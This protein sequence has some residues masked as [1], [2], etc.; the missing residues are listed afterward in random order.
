MNKH[1]RPGLETPLAQPLAGSLPRALRTALRRRH[2]LLEVLPGESLETGAERIDTAVMALFRD[3]RDSLAFECLYR[4]TSAAVLEWLRRL[5]GRDSRSLDPL[6]ALQDTFINV[7]QYSARFRDERSDSFRVW[8]RTIAANALRR[9]CGRVPR[10]FES[11]E[12]ANRPEPVAPGAEPEARLCGLEDQRR[13]ALSWMLFLD[14]YG[15]AFALLSDRDQAALTLVE[16]E[17]LSYAEAA[18]RLAVGSSNMKMIM[19]RARQRL[20]AHMDRSMGGGC[21]PELRAV[22]RPE[23][24]REAPAGKCPAGG[25]RLRAVG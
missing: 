13:L 10:Q 3:T 21:P 18:A 1:V 24:P 11:D 5:M 6:E 16:V 15:R 8:V 22:A 4:R 9:A 14:H 23:L 12:A 2:V 25:P 7:Y 19:F 20:L 17:G